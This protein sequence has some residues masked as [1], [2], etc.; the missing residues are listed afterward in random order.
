MLYKNPPLTLQQAF[1]TKDKIIDILSVERLL[2]TKKIH[3]TL[4]KKYATSITY[5][6]VHK[7]LLQLQI[8]KVIVKNSKN[9]ELDERWIED[10]LLFFKRL[11][12]SYKSEKKILGGKIKVFAFDVN[13]VLT[14]EM[15]HVEF[16]KSSDHYQ[17]IKEIVASQTLGKIPIK[18]AFNKISKLA[19]G[20]SLYEVVKYSEEFTLMAGVEE[21]VKVLKD[22][23][24]KV[25][26]ITTGFKV[27]MHAFNQRLGNPFDFIICNELIFATEEG[28]E[29]PLKEIQKIVRR[30]NQ[31]ELKRIKIKGIK[32][33]IDK[34]EKKTS[35]L[36]QYLNKNDFEMKDAACVGDSMGD[37][38]FIKVAGEEGG[39]GI[40]FNPNLSLIEYA[41]YLKT[42]GKNVK[43][44][45]SKD[46]RDI[47][48]LFK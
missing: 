40:A 46:L 15:T 18:K 2:S 22:N 6:A 23:G 47:I 34:E 41:Q 12:S 48:N 31:N 10:R 16:A 21:M 8:E 24:V 4:K 36:R 7:L 38:D 42:Q 32:L 25:G 13:G 30:K 27:A 33:V 9:W 28:K 26:L 35:M 5:Q 20:T 39:V 1:S 44:V 14:P 17:E 37:A 45:Q 3:S 29:I 19:A 43:I 11:N